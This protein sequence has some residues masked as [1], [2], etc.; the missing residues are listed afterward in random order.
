MSRR[1]TLWRAWVCALLIW[2]AASAESAPEAGQSEAEQGFTSLF[3]GK[4]LT[5]WS[6]DSAFWRV[7]DGAIVGTTTAEKPLAKGNTFAVWEGSDVVPR[8]LANFEIRLR[9]RFDVDANNSGIQ[10]RSR[11]LPE[12][13]PWTIAGE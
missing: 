13:S 2:Q 4:D 10:I 5:G 9:Y 1:N 6:A 12:V 11:L 3:N 8:S 7:E